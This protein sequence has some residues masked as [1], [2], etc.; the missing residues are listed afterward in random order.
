MA[1]PE[2]NQNLTQ[3]AQ[4]TASSKSLGTKIERFLTNFLEVVDVVG[5]RLMGDLWKT[6]YLSIQDAIALAC[7]LKL[8]G[9]IGNMIIGVEFSSLKDCLREDAWGV[10]RYAC[11]I[12]VIADFGLW[13]VLGGRVL[14]RCLQDFRDLFKKRSA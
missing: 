7:L 8:P 6:F 12:I 1:Q 10:S 3:L 2:R 13:A 5:K 11:F 9:I 4:S 14:I